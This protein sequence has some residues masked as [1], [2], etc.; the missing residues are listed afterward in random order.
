MNKKVIP[1]VVRLKQ[2]NNEIVQGIAQNDAGVIFDITVMDGLVPFDFSGYSIVALKIKKPDETFTYDSTSGSYV[3]IVDP[4]KGRLK[5]NIPTSC[6]AQNGMHY[7]RVSFSSDEST[8]FE[9]M[10][11]NYFVGEDPNAEDSEVI[12]TNEFPVLSNLIAQVSGMVNAETI[13]TNNEANREDAEAERQ[14][15]YEVMMQNLSTALAETQ[16]ALANANAMLEQV[17]QAIAQGGSIDVSDISALATKSYVEDKVTHL[18]F[19]DGTD[20]KGKLQIYW[21][22]E[23]TLANLDIGE[24]AYAFDTKRLYIGGEN[25]AYPDW[26]NEPCFIASTTAPVDSE[27]HPRNTDKLWIDTS[28]TA[29]VIKYYNGTN[30]VNCNTAVFA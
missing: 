15:G 26:I 30:W 1:I 7:C 27:E 16:T 23:D 29:P 5:I 6:T 12:G 13:R 3:D 24:L 2:N 11:F 4:T 14:A 9:A 19:G 17:Y 8:L 20:K 21:G 22:E 25:N 28:G 18:D 10:M